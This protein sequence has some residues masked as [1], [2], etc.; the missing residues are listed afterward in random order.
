MTF[1]FTDIIQLSKSPLLPFFTPCFPFLF[2]LSFILCAISSFSSDLFLPLCVICFLFISFIPF[3]VITLFFS[4][5]FLIPLILT[6]WLSFYSSLSFLLMFFPSLVPSSIH[7]VPSFLMQ[8]SFLIY[9]CPPFFIFPI[10][11]S[12]FFL[13]FYLLS[14]LPCII[15][16]FPMP[17]SFLVSFCL[18][19]FFFFSPYPSVVPSYCVHCLVSLSFL[20]VSVISRTFKA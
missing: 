17:S 18:S 10:V 1:V 6:L 20:L 3:P 16:H 11:F 19:L 5:S 9:L 4:R 13:S 7:C 15:F 12:L 2:F 8:T 14:F